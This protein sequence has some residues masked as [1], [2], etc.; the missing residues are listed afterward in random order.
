MRRHTALL[1]TLLAAVLS[2]SGLSLQAAEDRPAVQGVDVDFYTG[3]ISRDVWLRMKQAGQEFVIVQ[4]WGG[5]SRNEFASSQLAGAR[6]IA[7]MKTAAY[8]LLN[9]DDKVCP[10]FADP[11][12]DAG[13]RCA[14]KLVAQEKP[15][16]RW[17]LE[18]G[19]AALGEEAANVSFIA[20]DVEWFLNEAPAATAAARARRRQSI[21]DAI[22]A[23]RERGHL[24][25]IYTRNAD[26]HWADI[27][28]CASDSKDNDCRDLHNT[29]N[30]PMRPIPLWDVQNGSPELGNFSP[31]GA[32]TERRGRQ[33]S[34]DANVFGLAKGRTLDLNVFDWSLFS[35]DR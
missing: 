27:T 31:H 33:Y 6:M 32:W 13:G 9:Y 8:V 16:G 35:Q 3:P 7:G 34:L 30:D 2:I 29:I 14:G 10:T 24:P 17:Q 20:I 1:K 19:I 5:R 11:Q 25:V 26:G 15:G 4:A 12:R 18:Q 22:T 28:G 23:A 21:T